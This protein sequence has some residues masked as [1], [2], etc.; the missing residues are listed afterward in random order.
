LARRVCQTWLVFYRYPPTGWV[1]V[2]WRDVEYG[3]PDDLR[4]DIDAC[5]DQF[6]SLAG[7]AAFFDGPGGTQVP[8]RVM[9]AIT[10]YFEKSC[11]NMGGAFASS[12]ATDAVLLGA[13]SAMADLLGA[14]DPGEIVFGASMTALTFNFT[15]ALGRVLG[16]GDAVVV[17]ELDHDANF[18]PWVCL[19]ERGVDV[20]VVPLRLDTFDI[21]Y[22]VLEQHLADGRVRW[23][24]CT[25]ASNALGTAPDLERVIKAAHAAGALVYVDAVQSVPHVLPNVDALDADAL[26]CSA[27]KFCGPHV[28]VLWARRQILAELPAYKL[29]PSKDVTPYR[30]E[31][32]TLPFELL[33][34]VEASVEYLADLSPLKGTRCEQLTDAYRSIENYEFKLAV[35]LTSGLSS[36]PGITTFGPPVDGKRVPTFALN[37]EGVAPLSVV[38]QLALKNICAW[39]GNY[40]AVNVM[41]RLS[42]AE[43]G[44]VRLGIVHYLSE[45]DVDRVVEGLREVVVG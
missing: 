15:R 9:T 44:T 10:H 26:A 13:R 30:W 37:V 36:I 21:D 20:R 7:G 11:A 1:G 23:V 34:G 42:L 6:P 3:M 19:A 32:G 25:A 18:T 38:K 2:W 14:S 40:Y 27:Y 12:R 33:A 5:R 29:R 35:Q 4:F 39:S 17:T 45:N 22:A 28:G 8:R 24:A 41:D 31:Q 16:P 43:N